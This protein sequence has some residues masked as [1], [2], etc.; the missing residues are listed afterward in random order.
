MNYTIKPIVC[1]YAVIRIGTDEII[2][3]CNIRENAE[4]IADILNADTD[5]SCAYAY[6]V[7]PNAK[8]KIV[9]PESEGDENG[10]RSL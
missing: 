9:K 3:I 7:Y 4:L 1:D 2:C 10:V 8:Y 5:N 6:G